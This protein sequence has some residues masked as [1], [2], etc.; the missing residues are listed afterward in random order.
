MRSLL[1][2]LHNSYKNDNI[3]LFS[4]ND[5]CRVQ[6]CPANGTPFFYSL[7]LET[8]LFDIYF[9]TYLFSSLYLCEYQFISGFNHSY[10]LYKPTQMH[11]YPCKMRLY[12][13]PIKFWKCMLK[14]H[15]GFGYH[16]IDGQ[17]EWFDYRSK[18]GQRNKIRIFFLDNF[19]REDFYV[20]SSI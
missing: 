7:F 5:L 3:S 13:Q 17:T 11:R 4:C 9:K 15:Y 8:S 2:V 18:D 10:K 6:M 20:H 16:V 1:T 14:Y 12:G 19:R